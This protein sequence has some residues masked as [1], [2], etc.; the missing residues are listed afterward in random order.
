MVDEYPFLGKCGYSN[1]CLKYLSGCGHCPQIRSYPTSWF[2]D[3]SAEMYKTKRAI[4][5]NLRKA[6]FVGPEYTVMSSKKSPLMKGIKTEILDEAIDVSVFVPKDTIRLREQLR[7]SESKIVLVCIAPLA[8]ERKGCKYFIEVA[9]RFENNDKFLFVHVGYNGDKSLLP[10]NYIAIGYVK[11]QNKLAEYYSLADLFVFPSLLDTMPNACL[12]A[13]ACGSPLLCFNTSGMPYLAN[14]TTAT[15]VEARSVEQMV[16]VITKTRK[17][18]Q[19]IINTCHEYA[20]NRYD[21][22]KY[23]AKL[24]KVAEKIL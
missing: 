5:K 16:A 20:V 9:R 1:G 15:F 2:F 12:E 7:I 18:T 24:T 8:Y 6:I 4:Y 17:K 14:E 22:K 10:S 23:Y 19:K 3:R 13:L 21:N 11:D